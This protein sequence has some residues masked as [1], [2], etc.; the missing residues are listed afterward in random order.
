MFQNCRC[1]LRAKTFAVANTKINMLTVVV[2]PNGNKDHR[3]TNGNVQNMP[4][5][6]NTLGFA[7]ATRIMN[8]TIR[9]RINALRVELLNL[10]YDIAIEKLKT[11]P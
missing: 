9:S 8:M 6:L 1:E 2:S 3:Q 5:K 7:T 11:S 10:C 4:P